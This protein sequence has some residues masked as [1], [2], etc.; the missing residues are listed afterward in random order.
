MAQ[1]R[2]LTPLIVGPLLILMGLL[3]LAANVYRFDIP[4]LRWMWYLFP[5]LLLLL[6]ITK[7]LR[8]FLW[9]HSRLLKNPRKGGLLSGLVWTTIGV[10]W[11]LSLAGFTGLLDFFGLYWPL[12]L[13]LFGLGKIIDYYRFHGKL[14]FRAGEVIGVLF[15][16]LVGLIVPTIANAHFPLL[17]FPIS[18]TDDDLKIGEIMGKRYSWSTTETVPA[19]D[20]REI[21]V[22]NLYGNVTIGSGSQDSVEISLT[23]E[24]LEQSEEAAEAIA[25]RV[26]ITT[27]VDG[28]ILRVGTNRSELELDKG[29]FKSHLKLKVPKQINVRVSNK[30]GELRVSDIDGVCEL[31][32]TYGDVVVARVIGNTEI[33]NSYDR[34]EAREVGGD[35]RVEN[36][37]GA[38]Q[39]EEVSGSAELKSDYD[40]ISA[41]QIGGDLLVTNR[42]GR[43]RVDRV[44]GKVGIEGPGSEVFVA[45]VENEVVVQNSHKKLTVRSLDSSL[46]I[47]TSYS[48]VE[49]SEIAGTV[50]VRANQSQIQGKELASGVV[51]NAKGSKISLKEIDGPFE[52]ATSLRNVEIEDFVGKGEIQNEYG[53][54]IL[55]ASRPFSEQLVASNKNGQITLKLGPRSAL[56]L[57]ARTVGGKVVSDFNL[58]LEK[59]SSTLETEMGRGG[60]EVRLQTTSADIRVLKK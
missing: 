12:L 31:S 7:L 49:L 22:T 56:K 44:G 34:V 29:R 58:E 10:F 9:E 55:V 46:G 27:S 40:S 28:A 24:V 39:V 45:D 57:S 26:E 13:V 19:N 23:K 21:E 38:I 17:E 33:T 52:I 53:E 42:F 60:P 30:Y 25:E 35:L 15:L 41:R 48:Q 43:I 2:S 36:H 37:R 3:F 14:Q 51:V 18:W 1:K 50:D 59:G 5:A 16:I 4:W 20:L 6:G 32:N 47:E 54:I 11:I 8:H